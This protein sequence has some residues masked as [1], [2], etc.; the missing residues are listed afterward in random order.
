[1]ADKTM[2]IASLDKI[3]INA[4]E[5]SFTRDVRTNI[6]LKIITDYDYL[7]GYFM[8][9]HKIDVLIIEEDLYRSINNTVNISNVF[10]LTEDKNNEGLFD[11]KVEYVYRY[12]SI[13]EIFHK[14]IGKAGIEKV[15]DNKSRNKSE[16]TKTIMVYSPIGGSGKTTVSLGISKQLSDLNK[17]VIYVSLQSLQD[18]QYYIH[19][20]EYV[21]N[22]FD[23]TL[24]RKDS[25]IMA[26][27]LNNIGNE[28]FDYLKAFDGPMMAYG[29]T[30][31]HYSYLINK[32]VESGIYDYIVMDTSSELNNQNIRIMKNVDEIVLIA[33]QGKYNECKI[34]QLL[35]CIEYSED[36]IHFVCNKFSYENKNLSIPYEIVEYVFCLPGNDVTYEDICKNNMLKVTTLILL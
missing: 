15:L 4:F 10:I 8:S 24:I 16:K 32:I 19:D 22:G 23:K 27:I 7:M 18:Y 9:P 17:K 12:S 26:E 28:G 31:E 25:N 13:K 6:N 14:V 33:Q 11:D 34:N 3:Y 29:L 2:V 1:M 35:N 5:I 36:K 21:A 30:D 20:Y